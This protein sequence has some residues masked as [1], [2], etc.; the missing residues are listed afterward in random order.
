MSQISENNN[1]QIINVGVIG[2]PIGH[3]K[4]PLIHN[5]FLKKFNINAIY[6]AYKISTENELNQF[7]D[8]VRN[9]NWAGFNITIPHKQAIIPYLDHVDPIVDTIQACNTVVVKNGQLYGHNTDAEGFYYPLSD[10]TIKSAIILGNG[11]ASRAVLYQLCKESVK[12]ICLVARNHS[13][14]AALVAQLNSQFGNKIQTMSFDELNN[15]DSA[16]SQ[17][18]LIINTTSVGMNAN[19]DP[20]GCIHLIS[21][22][23][24]YYDLIYN[25][26][27]TKMARIC[28]ENGATLING[29][30]MLA[31]Q[32][33]LAF[34]LF[35]NQLPSTEAMHQ[36][37]YEGE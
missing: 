27:E 31:H 16:I 24:I 11:G 2:N 35:F 33:A 9:N 36:L 12:T 21:N 18:Q 28:K 29:A 20:F 17:Y 34:Q 3:S 7:I 30:I 6:D 15:N 5:F 8:T 19:D 1:P 22:G 4:S 23:Q 14:S 26:W 10:H 37:I 32:G 25:P 13:K